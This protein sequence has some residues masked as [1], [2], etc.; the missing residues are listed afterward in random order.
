M[1]NIVEDD[2]RFEYK[3]KVKKI[4][5]AESL[6]LIQVQYTLVLVVWNFFTSNL[7]IFSLVN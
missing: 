2:W 1:H 6:R 4:L 7:Q 5:W 3:M